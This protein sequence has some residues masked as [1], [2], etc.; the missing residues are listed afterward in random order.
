M[1]WGETVYM[2]RRPLI[3]LLHQPRM[4]DEYGAFGEMRIGRGNRSTRRKP[5]EYH[6]ALHKSY[7][8]TWVRTRVAAVGSRRLNA[9]A[10]TRPS[11][12]N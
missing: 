11:R 5:A 1:G 7:T 3:G 12:I 10:M 2:V 4:I 6:S 8:M 9:R